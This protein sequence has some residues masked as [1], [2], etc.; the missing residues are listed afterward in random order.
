M[1]KKSKLKNSNGQISIFIIVVVIVILLFL[2]LVFMNF[3]DNVT[4]DNIKNSGEDLKPL[5]DNIDYCL[6]KQLKR[7]LIISG[8]KGGFIYDNGEYY[9]PSAVP[10]NTYNGDFISNLNLN[11]NNIL[12]YTL[13]HSQTEVYS[14]L[15]SGTLSLS[16][17]TGIE[18][19]YSHSIE[20]DFEK[21]VLDEF[22]KCVNLESYEK[23]GYEIRFEEYGGKVISYVPGERYVK[24][25]GLKNAQIGDTI[26]LVTLEQNFFAQI[27]EDEGRGVFV[28][29]L[30]ERAQII[31]EQDINSI[32]VINLN[33]KINLEII[34][35]DEKVTADLSFPVVLTTNEGDFKYDNSVVSVDV[36]FRKLLEMSKIL[37]NKKNINKS[38]NYFNESDVFKSLEEYDYVTN[39]NFKD[40]E[41]FVTIINDTDEYKRYVYSIID[42]DSRILGNPYVFNF[43]YENEAP[44]IN[45][46]ELGIKG[47]S[48]YSALF[49]VS[50]NTLFELNL[51]S[52][53]SDPQIVDN[54]FS[55][56]VEDEYHGLDADYSLTADGNLSFIG[57]RET[58]F[59]YDVVVSD[60]ETKRS[61]SIVFLVGFP[62]NENNDDVLKCMSFKNYDI[63]N[64]FPILDKFR[65]KIFTYDDNGYNRA[66]G[67]S[68]YIDSLNSY[69]SILPQS[70]VRFDKTC[71]FF[72]DYF[73][74]QIEVSGVTNPYYLDTGD[75]IEIY[76]P[77]ANVPLD[78]SVTVMDKNTNQA[79]TE[80]FKITVFPSNCLG[81]EP[82][83]SSLQER[84]GG[85]MSCC[86]VEGIFEKPTGFIDVLDSSGR[87][88]IDAE[89]YF[90]AD[91]STMHNNYDTFGDF[92]SYVNIFDDVSVSSPTSLY[93]G[94]II[95][96][97]DGTTASGTISEV[98]PTGSVD[99]NE[100]GY[101]S[102]EGISSFDSIDLRL[103][104]VEDASE[105]E[106]CYVGKKSGFAV[107]VEDSDALLGF[108]SG[109]KIDN[110]DSDVG[111]SVIPNDARYSGI[112]VL[113]D[114]N[115]YAKEQSGTEGWSS[116]EV[117]IDMAL[118]NFDWLYVSKGY[119]SQGRALCEGR[120][121]AMDTVRQKDNVVDCVDWY[122]DGSELQSVV[123]D[124][125]ICVTG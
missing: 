40:F 114:N 105:C 55:Y 111:V 25:S 9:S 122:F 80:P 103:T 86:N 75:Y 106:F 26:K 120:L 48:N 46:S 14:P 66:Y 49:I 4:K 39:T 60:G 70:V 78:V 61:H 73:E 89:S 6:E 7:A 24:V 11:W 83:D 93:E 12:F 44:R 29:D 121:D 77:I 118:P 53:T 87:R 94:R 32:D 65:N 35:E 123:R 18:Q 117:G 33:A 125:S 28:V 107:Y 59:V 99:L 98:L 5:K 72:N 52:Y 30:G 19:I 38:L 84:V 82:V 34:F 50:K 113:C 64:F 109:L 22:I 79:I 57:H 10:D 13:I 47:I 92:F 31:T 91:I 108:Y 90:C 15:I 96:V 74:P 68:L 102:S 8:L 67:Y 41:F 119:C 104:K 88:S 58:K 16:R 63:Q 97:C 36:R 43:G 76:V 2:F 23:E 51:Q 56:Y 27:I 115:K 124:W 112:K 100:R 17:D 37:L 1:M 42:K 101:V 110:S 62:D 54:Y 21:F 95:G 85:T 81:P 20:E 116:N 3:D 71:L 45:L 69:S